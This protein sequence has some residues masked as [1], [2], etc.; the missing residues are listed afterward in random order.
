MKFIASHNAFGAEFHRLTR[1]YRHFDW[2]IAWAGV[3]HEAFKYL[4]THPAKVRRIVVGTHFHQTSPT[5]IDA[6]SGIAN[7][8]FRLDQDSLSGV[9]HPKLYVF[10]NDADDWEALVGSANFTTG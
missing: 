1:Q 10:S 6:V 9:F 2:A 5:F 4:V 7:V 3:G 8:R